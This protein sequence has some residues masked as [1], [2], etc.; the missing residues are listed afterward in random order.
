MVMM[1]TVVQIVVMHTVV[2]YM[3]MVYMATARGTLLIDC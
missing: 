3:A 2:V 1:H